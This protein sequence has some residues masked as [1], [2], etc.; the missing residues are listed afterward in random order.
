MPGSRDVPMAP[1]P[2][3]PQAEPSSPRT[4]RLPPAFRNHRH[5]Q[6]DSAEVTDSAGK[7]WLSRT[8]SFPRGVI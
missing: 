6:G 2:Q 7:S 4:A 3:L 1:E 5:K 8:P